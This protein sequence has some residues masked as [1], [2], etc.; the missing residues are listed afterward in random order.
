MYK[1]RDMFNSTDYVLASSPANRSYRG[2]FDSVSLEEVGT[3]YSY[4]LHNVF[5]ISSLCF[6]FNGYYFQKRLF[7][8]DFVI[9][10]RWSSLQFKVLH[11]SEIGI[12]HSQ[13]L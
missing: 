4:F 10:T 5:T 12:K 8:S 13:T 6:I 7:D 3:S 2:W 11:R 9:H 1:K